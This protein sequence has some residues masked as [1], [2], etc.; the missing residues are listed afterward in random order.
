MECTKTTPV[1][2]IRHQKPFNLMKHLRPLAMLLLAVFLCAAGMPPDPSPLQF[3]E[4]DYQEVQQKAKTEGK[5]YLLHFAAEHVESCTWMDEHTFTDQQ[6]SAYLSRSY[7]SAKINIEK[8][9]GAKLQH[10]FR[11]N[12][13][14]TTLIFSTKGELV[15]ELKGKQTADEMIAALRGYDTP[16]HRTPPAKVK[17]GVARPV[18]YRTVKRKVFRPRL[19]PDVLVTHRP[20]GYHQPA[21]PATATASPRHQ[22]QYPSIYTRPEHVQK[23]SQPTAFY[24]IQV[25]VFS[26]YQNAYRAKSN[27][28]RY[29]NEGH[30]LPSKGSNGRAMYRLCAGTF[31]NKTEAVH[32]QRKIAPRYP[33]SFVKRVQK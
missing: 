14:P 31:S 19:V 29:G 11:I 20:G 18:A 8:P 24:S 21:Q 23:P 30:L 6:L 10:Q 7:L 15:G 12:L 4:S 27:L 1:E 22:E 26:N 32:Y 28:E 3:T 9:E 25:G 13:L 2:V 5:L 16:E 33:D 17:G